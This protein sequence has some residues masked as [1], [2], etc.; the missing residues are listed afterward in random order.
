ME[1]GYSEKCYTC[2]L[3]MKQYTDKVLWA[4]WCCELGSKTQSPGATGQRGYDQIW[5]NKRTANS[6]ATDAEGV[7]AKVSPAS[8]DQDG[9]VIYT[10]Q[11]NEPVTALRHWSHTQR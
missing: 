8:R 5:H 11:T 2:T 1:S 6:V 9:G 3:H 10:A 4:R 7:Q